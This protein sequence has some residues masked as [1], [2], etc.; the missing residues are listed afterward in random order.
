MRFPETLLKRADIREGEWERVVLMT[1]HLL[2]I[3]ASYMI[4]K[5]VRDSLFVS[6]IGPAQLPYVYILIAAAMGVVSV[7]FTRVV[8][9]VGLESLIQITSYLAISNLLLFWWGFQ[10]KST[11]LFY[12]LYVWVSLFGAITASQFWLLANYVFNPREARRLFGWLALGGIVGGMLGG[13]ATKF[14]APVFGTEWLLALV[15]VLMGLT[16]ILVRRVGAIV[17]REVREATAGA[18][19]KDETTKDVF[20]QVRQSRHLSLLMLLLTFSVIVEALI[21]YE[22]KFSAKQAFVSKDQLTAFFG[23]VTAYIGAFSLLFQ[24]L[25]T[26]PIL[27]R[28]G[29]GVAILFLPAGLLAASVVLAVNPGLWA[30]AALQLVDGGFGYSIH[31]SGMELLYLPIPSRV[32]NAAKNFIDTFVD[33]AG[34]AFGGVLLLV[35]TS[36]LALSIG[37]ISIIACGFLGLWLIAAILIKSEYLQSFRVALEKKNV[38]PEALL[39]SD[40]DNATIG[41]LVAALSSADERQVLYALDILAEVHP[42]RWKSQIPLLTRHPSSAVRSRALTVLTPWYEQSIQPLI[43]ELLHDADVSVRSK[44]IELLCKND[45]NPAERLQKFLEHPDPSIVHAAMRCAAQPADGYGWEP[46]ARH[47]QILQS[48]LYDPA[49]ETARQ[50]MATIGAVKYEPALPAVIAKLE[51]PQ[52]RVDASESLLKF[53]GDAIPALSATL[54]DRTNPLSLRIRVPKALAN[55]SR[56]EAADVLLNAL[57]RFEY[58]V[59]Y[60]LM[61]AMNRMRT[62]SAE[63]AFDPDKVRI[64][65]EHEAEAY[66]RLRIILESLQAHPFEGPARSVSVFSI[67]TK[68]VN[69]R[70]QHHV[71]RV[72]RLLALIHPPHDIYSAYYTCLVKP[73]FRP[74][75]IEF[76]DNLLDLKTKPLTVPLI[77]EAFGLRSVEIEDSDRLSQEAALCDLRKGADPWLRL[78]AEDIEERLRVAA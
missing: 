14:L 35:L 25:L 19:L 46:S 53:G 13:G 59:D 62:S 2:V 4:V 37:R 70:V 40:L 47:E 60:R 44:A 33:R 6:T 71:E 11:V 7:V 32:K 22:Y 31:R 74:N 75:A 78:I 56:Q 72:F 49:P 42:R 55:A 23:T 8:H 18:P 76:L 17:P 29:A 77:E 21:D 38:Q 64:A 67:L 51:D 69:E 57:H 10:H 54:E 48:L 43:S 9:R 58:E 20:R 50:A 61:K 68:A 73:S 45:P 27:K 41:A 26:G 1:I 63:I 24:I 36:V 52:L 12:V 30:A 34:R 5:A 65:L 28:F 39:A 16:V 66:R 3:I 15:A